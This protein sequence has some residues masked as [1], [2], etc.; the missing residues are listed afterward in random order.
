MKHIALTL[1]AAYSI[2]F[3]VGCDRQQG[4]TCPSGK[5]DAKVGKADGHDHDHDHDKAKAKGHDA[6]HDHKGDAPCDHDSGHSHGGEKLVLGSKPISKL[7]VEV[8]QFGKIGPD[9]KELV[10]EISVKGD[11]KPFAVR[12]VVRTPDGKESMKVKADTDS[13]G[14]Y[15]AHVGELPKPLPAASQVVIEVEISKDVKGSAAFALK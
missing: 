11:E 14:K 4:G 15:D 13:P 3:A 10:F 7:A 1:I 8:A 9:T 5:A 2:A 6:D 12:A